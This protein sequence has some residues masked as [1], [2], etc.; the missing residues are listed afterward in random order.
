[1]L[2]T[3]EHLWGSFSPYEIRYQ[4]KLGS[5]GV[6]KVEEMAYHLSS[7]FEG[8]TLKY[9]INESLDSG[10]YYGPTVFDF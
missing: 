4:V 10:V 9:F 3:G 5:R 1:M 8:S 6:K 2:H 7:S